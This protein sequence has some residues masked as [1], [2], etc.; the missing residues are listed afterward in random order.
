MS[1]LA[2][3]LGNAVM[4]REDRV[5]G[6]TAGQALLGYSGR[7]GA[8]SDVGYT[9]LD[10]P[11][12]RRLWEETRAQVFRSAS[13]FKGSSPDLASQQTRPAPTA[14]P[15]AVRALT[16]VANELDRSRGAIGA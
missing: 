13:W 1:S 12:A 5:R 6:V 8:E 9:T 14:S 2:F 7:I 16:D 10:L 4:G 15:A 3:E 11:R